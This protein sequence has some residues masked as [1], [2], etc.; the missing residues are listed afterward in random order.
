MKIKQ[1]IAELQNANQEAEISAITFEDN[2]NKSDDLIFI[3]DAPNVSVKHG[4]DKSI[5]DIVF[6]K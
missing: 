3:S 1:L 2:I 5:V 6:S 4:A